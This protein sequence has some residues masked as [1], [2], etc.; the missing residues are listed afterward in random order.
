MYITCRIYMYK[1][2]HTVSPGYGEFS[3]EPW[4]ELR[5]SRRCS[6]AVLIILP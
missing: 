6:Q 2:D 5:R 1:Y 3:G 4:A